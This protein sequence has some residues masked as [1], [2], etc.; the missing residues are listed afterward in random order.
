MFDKELNV[1]CPMFTVPCAY[2]ADFIFLKI[3]LIRLFFV[4]CTKNTQRL[5][6]VRLT[7]LQGAEGHDIPLSLRR[8]IWRV[9]VGRRWSY[10]KR[11]I[12]K[13]RR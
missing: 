12:E 5:A 9:G 4:L 7:R 3:L 1:K 2:L 6:S 13:P 8:D 11:N 10:T